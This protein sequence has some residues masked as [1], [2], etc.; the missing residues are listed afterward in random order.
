MAQIIVE[1]CCASCSH[2]VVFGVACD[3]QPDICPFHIK[4]ESPVK[5]ATSYHPVAEIMPIMPE[6]YDAILSNN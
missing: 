4:V 2:Q 1:N 5:N 6:E 3:W